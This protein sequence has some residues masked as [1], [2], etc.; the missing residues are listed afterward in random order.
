M[1]DKKLEEIANKYGGYSMKD[2]ERHSIHTSIDRLLN[3]KDSEIDRLNREISELKSGEAI[4]S[5][6]EQLQNVYT[7]LGIDA[8]GVNK[9]IDAIKEHHLTME[10][11]TISFSYVPG[12]GYVTVLKDQNGKEIYSGYEY[13]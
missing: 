4:K 1:N 9:A 11:V 3:A 13:L 7:F 6:I 10:D 2:L 8:A 5:Y 12:L